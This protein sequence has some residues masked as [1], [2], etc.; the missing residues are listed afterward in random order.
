[1]SNW[2]GR[3]RRLNSSVLESNLYNLLK[4]F[5]NHLIEDRETAKM[6]SSRLLQIE[7]ALGK[8]TEILSNTVQA[9]GNYA[10]ETRKEIGDI[11][12]YIFGNHTNGNKGVSVRIEM[13]EEAHKQHVWTLRT[14]WAFIIGA[15]VK[16]FFDL[17]RNTK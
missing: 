16:F 11:N 8:Q 3:E 4:A 5:E 12:G 2:D 15:V 6:L 13:L 1:M 10:M 14:V 7:L 9:M 17:A